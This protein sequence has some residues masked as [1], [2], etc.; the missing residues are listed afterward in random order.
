[1]SIKI[2]ESAKRVLHNQYIIQYQAIEKLVN[3]SW[4]HVEKAGLFENDISGE[5]KFFCLLYPNRQGNAVFV[6]MKCPEESNWTTDW[7]LWRKPGSDHPQDEKDLW[8]E[9]LF[10]R[11]PNLRPRLEKLTEVMNIPW[12]VPPNEAVGPERLEESKVKDLID[13]I[14]SVYGERPYLASVLGFDRD[15]WIDGIVKHIMTYYQEQH[16]SG[17]VYELREGLYICDIGLTNANAEWVY[18]FLDG[19]TYK[20]YPPRVVHQ[21][22]HY[23]DEKDLIYRFTENAHG[24]YQKSYP[25]LS[26]WAFITENDYKE[27]SKMLLP[28]RWFFLSQEGGE[29]WKAIRKYLENTFV[30][31]LVQDGLMIIGNDGKKATTLDNARLA[32]FHTGLVDEIYQPIYAIFSKN[33][34]DKPIWKL[35]GF[36]RP[37]QGVTKSLPYLP[38]RATYFSDMRDMFYDMSVS[39]ARKP[40]FDE[41]HILIERFD[42]LPKNVQMQ[43]LD[44]KYE[45]YFCAVQNRKRDDARRILEER[46]RNMRMQLKGWFQSALEMSIHRAEWNYRTGVPMYYIREGVMT[47]LLPLALEQAM[48][49]AI[50][51]DSPA[52]PPDLALA[53]SLEDDNNQQ[54]HKEAKK[55][56]AKTI[57]ALDT[58]YSNSRLVTRPDSDWLKPEII[59][60]S[61]IEDD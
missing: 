16:E 47:I 43:F 51:D 33:N 18:L 20:L 17:K 58:A 56:V 39:N 55:Y 1:M 49:D 38:E 12:V 7:V 34:K 40:E 50:L 21:L 57:L 41:G 60:D 42:R 26:A 35:A 52:S 9:N 24:R 22:W 37:H 5:N 4:Q 30:R 44:D 27:L 48:N 2:S 11:F 36:G 53:M 45:E 32:A 3:D 8:N 28:E 29:E 13:S 31:L 10:S 54:P 61:G 6:Q 46:P 15:V 59:V 25:L 23:P 19:N 14:Y